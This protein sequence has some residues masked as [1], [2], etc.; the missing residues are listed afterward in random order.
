MLPPMGDMLTDLV[1]SH[2]A[3]PIKGFARG[4][5]PDAAPRTIRVGWKRALFV[6]RQRTGSWP[7]FV[8]SN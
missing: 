6:I 2:Q 5:D 1:G 8:V 7:N 4:E 3:I